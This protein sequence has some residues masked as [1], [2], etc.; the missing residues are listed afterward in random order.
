[1]NMS[2][3]G[4]HVVIPVRYGSTRL[5]GKPLLDLCGKPM[6]HHVCT[7]ALEAGADQVVVATDDERIAAAVADLPALVVMTR[8]DHA[9]GTERLAEVVDRL[10]WDEWTIVVNL[11]GD[12][13]FME[14]RLIRQLARAL[15]QRPDCQVATLATPIIEAEAA[16]DPNIVK[17]VTD[18][19]SRALYFSRATIPWDRDAFAG[20]GPVVGLREE[21][22]YR[23]HIGIYAY[24]VSYL[25]RYVGLSPSP[26][27]RIEQLEQLRILWHGDRILVV[28]VTSGPAPGIDT[29]LDL[30][31]AERY[32]KSLQG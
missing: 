29:E 14:G 25:R 20:G 28:P 10:Q 13:P 22:L 7:R 23:R 12:E 27:E 1:M 30:E 21:A 6:I 32:L 2:D 5:P 31:R 8:P 17:V 24:T 11:Q 9:S 18:G 16:F 15:Q 26:L 19:E 4:F 3:S